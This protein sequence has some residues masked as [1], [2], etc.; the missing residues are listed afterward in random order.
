VPR[1]PLE[2][3]GVGIHCAHVGACAKTP[4]RAGQNDGADAIVSCDLT[5]QRAQLVIQ[6]VIRGIHDLRAVQGN[7]PNPVLSIVQDRLHAHS[8]L[9]LSSVG[10]GSAR[11]PR[12]RILPVAPLGRSV[13]MCTRLG[14]L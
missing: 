10:S 13:R 14:T 8:M 4:A 2:R 11:R 7:G 5:D 12:R 9:V 3:A 1:A 6:R